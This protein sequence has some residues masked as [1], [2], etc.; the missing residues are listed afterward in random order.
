MRMR[1]LAARGWRSRKKEGEAGQVVP[2][3]LISPKRGIPA[4]VTE[5]NQPVVYWPVS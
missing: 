5:G 4:D 1:I 3:P 2:P